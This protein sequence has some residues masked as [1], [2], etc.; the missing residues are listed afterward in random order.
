M[1]LDLPTAAV[2]GAVVLFFFVLFLFVRR[3]LTSFTEGFREGGRR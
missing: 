3:I 1:A 2:I